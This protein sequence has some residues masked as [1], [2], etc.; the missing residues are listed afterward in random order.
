MKGC[1]TTLLL[2]LIAAF[3]AAFF[4]RSCHQQT[5]EQILN[6]RVASN[7]TNSYPGV[8]VKYDHLTAMV[9][10]HATEDQVTEIKAKVKELAIGNG[11]VH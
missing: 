2:A 5:I 4:G 6:E 9:S 11:R 3:I 8:N 1:F 7:I 10:G